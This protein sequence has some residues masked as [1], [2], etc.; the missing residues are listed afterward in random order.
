MVSNGQTFTS[1]QDG[2]WSDPNT[3]DDGVNIPESGDVAII[4]GHEV[5]F[6]SNVTGEVE[7]VTI[8]NSG[9]LII[10]DFLNVVSTLSTSGGGG[11]L[12]LNSFL[13]VE[14]LSFTGTSSLAGPGGVA[15]ISNSLNVPSGTLTVGAVSLQVA[16]STISGTISYTSTSGSKNFNGPINLIGGTINFG[17]AETTAGSGARIVSSGTSLITGTAVGTVNLSG[18][19]TVSAGTLTVEGVNLSVSGATSIAGALRF[20]SSTSGSKSFQNITVQAGGAW[21]NT[22]AESFNIS[23][24]ITNSG[25]WTGCS[26]GTSCIYTLSS[27]SGLIQGNGTID[28]PDVVING[29]GSYTNIASLVV[30]DRLTGSGSFINGVN[31][32]LEY[33]GNNSTGS[34]FDITNFTASA[35]GNTVT[36]AG[37][38]NQLIRQTTDANNTYYNLVINTSAAGN[39]VSLDAAS[40]ISNRLTLTMGDLVLGNNNL[41]IANGAT[42]TGGNINS[43]IQDSGTGVVRYEVS[44]TG[45]DIYVPLGGTNFSPITINLSSATFGGSSSIDFSL[46]DS[47]HPNRDRNNTGDSPAGDDDGTVAIDYLDLYWTIAGNNITDPVFTAEYVY[48]ATD[49][50]QLTE[51]NLI[52]TLYRTLPGGSTLDWLAIGLVNATNNTAHMSRGD[53]FGDLYAMDNSME[54]LPVDLLSFKVIAGTN[55]VKL[56]WKTSKEE[57]NSHFSIERSGDGMKFSEVGSVVGKGTTDEDQLYHFEDKFP[58]NGR[59]YY[60][61]RQVDFN[62][63]YSFSEVVSVLYEKRSSD[64]L[65]LKLSSNYI[66]QGQVIHVELSEM[67]GANVEWA[68]SDINGKSFLSDKIGGGRF[69]IETSGMY[70]GMYILRVET[71]DKQVKSERI[72]IR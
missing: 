51:S 17:V 16:S 49:F 32:S 53:G 25:T 22:V 58:L 19:L 65:L 54:R 45:N 9:T 62:G 68:I 46:T 38:S 24:N 18:S 4:D 3:W 26:D 11:T 72:I 63:Q 52:P 66:N 44:S 34:N 33:R 64:V 14:T 55:G 43:F 12:T 8:Q 48:D 56:N 42:I 59:S 37:S 71:P 36:F 50:T 15:S 1:V 30:G 57:N 5:T 35:T 7:S 20:A 69:D 67:D 2:N 61:L 13:T 40:R 29:T 23:G 21:N 27:S 39:D 28:M 70:P 60:R 6:D 31:A 41:T 10:T 47:A